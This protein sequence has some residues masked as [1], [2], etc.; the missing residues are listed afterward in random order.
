MKSAIFGQM[1]TEKSV[2]ERIRWIANK[3]CLDEKNRNWY[4]YAHISRLQ[5]RSESNILKCRKTNCIRGS[6]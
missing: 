3:R 5:P 1:K 4:L 2:Q 6:R